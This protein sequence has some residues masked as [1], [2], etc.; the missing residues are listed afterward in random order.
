[1][2]P[3]SATMAWWHE[4]WHGSLGCM[5]AWSPLGCTGA[6]LVRARA[7]RCAPSVRYH[8]WVAC[9]VSG[10]DLAR[11]RALVPSVQELVVCDAWPAVA[12]ERRVCDCQGVAQA[13]CG[14]ATLALLGCPSFQ[15]NWVPCASC[16]CAFVSYHG[17]ASPAWL[18]VCFV[19]HRLGL[20][21][22]ASS[23]RLANISSSSATI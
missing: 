5:C 23:A 15:Q 1:M 10:D 14:L 9:L 4:A 18:V 6:F 19:A 17:G 12:C 22:R 3:T 13:R 20:A 16:P 7:L 11:S 21:F 2:S 8:S